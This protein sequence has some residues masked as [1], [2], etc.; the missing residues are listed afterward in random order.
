MYEFSERMTAIGALYQTDLLHATLV[1]TCIQLYATDPLHQKRA[2]EIIEEIGGYDTEIGDAV[3]NHLRDISTFTSHATKVNFRLY[4][5]AT[6][7]VLCRYAFVKSNSSRNHTRFELH[8]K[9]DG[10]YYLKIADKNVGIDHYYGKDIRRVCEADSSHPN[11]LWKFVASST[12]PSRWFR[13]VNKATGQAL[14]HYYGKSI[15]SCSVDE[16]PNH[17]WEVLPSKDGNTV[18]IVNCATGALLGYETKHHHID[19]FAGYYT[20]DVGAYNASLPLPNGW[21]DAK[22][23]LIR[24]DGGEYHN[25]YSTLSGEGIDY[26]DGE[27][28]RFVGVPS[29]HPN[30]QWKLEPTQTSDGN[31][32]YFFIRNKA[33][34]KVLDHY[35]GKSLAGT[36]DTNADSPHPNHIWKIEEV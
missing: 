19:A 14:D 5:K 10:Y 35:Y 2:A 16:H 20:I 25:L 27:S 17:L 23:H 26:Y 18:T 22:W 15:K 29:G 33:T 13:I 34:S 7:Q 8:A 24:Q 6:G 31:K 21:L 4:N 9:G 36:D 32:A 28:F 1:L 11:H 3:S 30:H 12:N